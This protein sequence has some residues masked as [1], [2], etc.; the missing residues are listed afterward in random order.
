MVLSN[1]PRLA[2]LH[3]Y[4]IDGHVNEEFVRLPSSPVGRSFEPCLQLQSQAEVVPLLSNIRI[5]PTDSINV[6][7]EHGVPVEVIRT[8]AAPLASAL[9]SANARLV[10]WIHPGSVGVKVV[11]ITESKPLFDLMIGTSES[12]WPADIQGLA[13]VISDGTPITLDVTGT[14]RRF[15][16]NSQIDQLD[17]ILVVMDRLPDLDRLILSGWNELRMEKVIK[18]LLSPFRRGGV[19]A[20]WSCPRL[21]RIENRHCPDYVPDELLRMI[22]TRSTACYRGAMSEMHGS[23]RE[24]EAAPVAITE[25]IIGHGS[26]MDRDTFLQMERIVGDGKGHWYQKMGCSQNCTEYSVGRW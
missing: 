2:F 8:L 3:W 22:R 13:R 16:L 25:V 7:V 17:A 19:S 21:E 6:Q 12:G 18:H 15:R 24:A 1:T 5:R 4:S 10:T 9:A 23:E 20:E 14:I 11:S 26:A